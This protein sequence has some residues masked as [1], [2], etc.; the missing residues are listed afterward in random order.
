M[1]RKSKKVLAD[2]SD[3]VSKPSKKQ[4][5]DLK[6]H[7]YPPLCGE[8]EDET[9]IKYIMALLQEELSKAKPHFDT[10]ASLMNCTFHARR[11]WILDNMESVGEIV[12]I[13]PFLSKSVY[14]G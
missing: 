4:K 5:I 8:I 7:T 3:E 6:K 9:S 10:V 11:Q 1:N 2:H 12:K 14:V 13:Y